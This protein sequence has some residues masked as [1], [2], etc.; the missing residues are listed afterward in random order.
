MHTRLISVFL[1]VV[2]LV[3]V[4]HGCGTRGP[5]KLYDPQAQRPDATGV[6]WVSSGLS[7]GWSGGQPDNDLRNIFARLDA[8]TVS[9]VDGV[10]IDHSYPQTNSLIELLQGKHRVEVIHWKQGYICG[11]FGCNWL[12]QNV[13]IIDLMVEAGHTYQP[14]AWNTC[15]RNWIWFSERTTKAEDVLKCAAS[16]FCVEKGN[17]IGPVVAGEYPPSTCETSQQ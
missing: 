9:K 11:L 6:I 17:D 1:G 7:F 16:R 15:G 13:E 12:K 2:L 8:A 3:G 10:N 5:I 4:L 14:Y